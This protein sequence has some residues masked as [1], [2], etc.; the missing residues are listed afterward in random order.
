MPPKLKRQPGERPTGGA[1]ST[2]DY[3]YARRRYQWSKRFNWIA[4]GACAAL[5][6]GALYWGIQRYQDWQWLNE[7]FSGASTSTR[8]S[9]NT[10]S[11]YLTTSLFALVTGALGIITF[12]IGFLFVRK[13][14]DED[15]IDDVKRWSLIAGVTGILPG[16]VFAGLLELFIWRAHAAENFTVFGLLGQAPEPVAATTEPVYNPA[17]TKAADEA[18]R[19]S[20]YMALFGAQQATPSYAPDYGYQPA[21][22]YTQAPAPAAAV[23]Y[24]YAPAA[25][26]GAAVAA[27]PAADVGTQYAAQPSGAPICTCGRP[28]EFVPEYNR[29]YCYT[30]DKYEGEA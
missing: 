7:H 24:G 3:E 25:A 2:V 29:Y 11:N 4:L 22:D 8:W 28:M 19:K 23:D 9:S 16:A 27:A 18:K 20:E 10:I 17:A 15:K 14:L 12:L 5:G 6:A 1:P 21:P 13:A 30:D 26:Q